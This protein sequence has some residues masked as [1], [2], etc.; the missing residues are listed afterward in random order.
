MVCIDK[1]RADFLDCRSMMVEHGEWTIEQ[2]KEVGADVAD[3]VNAG[4]PG[5]LQFW[6]DWFAIRGEAARALRLIGDA[7]LNNLRQAA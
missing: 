6:C 5:E 2:S 7:V 3:A 1:L 4:V